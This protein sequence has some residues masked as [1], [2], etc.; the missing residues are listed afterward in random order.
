MF[1][2]HPR[3]GYFFEAPHRQ[4]LDISQ[5]SLWQFVLSICRLSLRVQGQTGV[6]PRHAIF[7]SHA[8]SGPH[9]WNV[10]ACTQ[11]VGTDPPRTPAERRHRS[12]F[13]WRRCSLVHALSKC[14]DVSDIG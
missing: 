11:G 3:A 2:E 12:V 1:L 4:P 10:V 5:L 8:I 13:R 9:H 14:E 7:G 6:G